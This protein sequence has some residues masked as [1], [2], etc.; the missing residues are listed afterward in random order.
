MRFWILLISLFSL[1]SCKEAYAQQHAEKKVVLITGA[2]RGIG[3]ATAEHLAKNGYRVYAGM[4]QGDFSSS[5]LEDLRFEILD[6]TETSTVQQAVRKIIEEEGHLDILI[7]NAGYGLIGPLEC[8]SMHEIFEQMDVNFFGVIRVCQEVLPQMRAQ[9]S[10]RII[11]ISSEQ[12]VYGQPFC[13]LYTSSKAALESLS[14]ALSI[15]VLPWNISLSIVEPGPVATD[16]NFAAKLGQKK[17]TANPYQRINDQIAEALKEKRVPSELYQSPEEVAQFLQAVIEDPDP[18]LR[19]QTSKATEE[20]VSL[21][22]K[23]ISG[24]EYTQRM[25]PLF[26]D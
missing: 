23:D 6:V 19:Y 2:S 5:S 17:L 18:R 13:S 12:G 22:L 4:R 8:L 24:R 9:K 16:C 11:N 3:R 14:E 7:N 10:G 26:G 20:K 21:Y 1:F 15:E 25:K